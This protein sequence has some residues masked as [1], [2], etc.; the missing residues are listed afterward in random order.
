MTYIKCTTCNGRGE[1]V[2]LGQLINKCYECNGTRFRELKIEQVTSHLNVVHDV[3]HNDAV[4]L[5]NDSATS[6]VVEEQKAQYE[7][8]LPKLNILQQLRAKLHG[9]GQGNFS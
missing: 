3:V 4:H 8:I 6:I 7:P 9:E 5:E 1:L 2:G